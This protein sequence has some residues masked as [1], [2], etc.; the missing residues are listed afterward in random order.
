MVEAAGTKAG[1]HFGEMRENLAKTVYFSNHATSRYAH[2][3]VI[4]SGI[5]WRIVPP[6]GGTRNERI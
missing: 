3:G 2:A 6:S 5:V 4:L 1:T